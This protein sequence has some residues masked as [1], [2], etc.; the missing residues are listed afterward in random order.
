MKKKFP[1]EQYN[2]FIYQ[3][4][5]WDQCGNPIYHIY[6]KEPIPD[7][8]CKELGIKRLKGDRY[9]V[10]SFSMYLTIDRIIEEIEL[11]KQEK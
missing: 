7:S 8:V 2:G 1:I 5:R 11:W 9:S 6:P 10:Q 3:K 4:I